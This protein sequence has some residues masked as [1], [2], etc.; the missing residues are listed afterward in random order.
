M[1]GF[2]MLKTLS[3]SA[4]ITSAVEHLISTTPFPKSQSNDFYTYSYPF[5]LSTFA[6][7]TR[8]K[9]WDLEAVVNAIGTVYSWMRSPIRSFRTDL[10]E[11]LPV[12][13]NN[14]AN[15]AELV[16]VA[17]QIVSNSLV[18]GSK[19]LHFYNPELYPIADSNTESWCWPESR[20]KMSEPHNAQRRYFEYKEGLEAVSIESK[21][22][23]QEW[24]E[25]W[26]GYSVTP[27][28]A[29]EAMIFYA[30]RNGA[31]STSI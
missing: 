2:I 18:A 15:P 11:A 25:A 21:K 10:L 27:I 23:A 20:S 3:P 22:A 1:S 9:S 26:F 16:P 8:E 24:A 5:F 17:C 6:R 30:A 28:R 7:H 31:I 14:Q 29:M 4:R 19:F 13:L 12:L